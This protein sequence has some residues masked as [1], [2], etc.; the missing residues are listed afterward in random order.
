MRVTLLEVL[1]E[2][3]DAPRDIEEVRMKEFLDSGGGG[4]NEPHARPRRFIRL[5]LAI[6]AKR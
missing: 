1:R 2:V 6:F 5:H 4:D 3:M